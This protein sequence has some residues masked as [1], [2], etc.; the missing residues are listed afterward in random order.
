MICDASART[1][2]HFGPLGGNSEPNQK[3][4]CKTDIQFKKY[5]RVPPNHVVHMSQRSP[6]PHFTEALLFTPAC[7]NTQLL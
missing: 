4:N 7:F 2:C 6:R 3:F 1:S 5:A